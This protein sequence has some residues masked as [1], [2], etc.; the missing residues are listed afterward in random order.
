MTSV[1][2]SFGIRIFLYP[3]IAKIKNRGPILAGALVFIAIALLTQYLAYQRILIQKENQRKMIMQE[4][5]TIKDRF[6]ILLRNSMAAT[7][8]LAFIV[9]KYGVKNDFDSIAATILDANELIDAVQITDKG[10]ITHVYPA[11]NNEAAIGLDLF[12]DSIRRVEALKAVEK[13]QLTFAGPF[14]LFQGG[15]AVVG[16]LP[17]FDDGVFLGFAAVIVR[18]QSLLM[19]CGINPENARFIYQFSKKNPHTGEEDF[20][21]PVHERLQPET[22]YSIMIPDGEWILSVGPKDPRTITPGTLIFAFLGLL[23]AATAGV[24]AWYLVQQPEKLNR[25]VRL[26]I[27]EIEK[28]KEATHTT[29]ERISD[30]FI[31]L[32]NRWCYTYINKKAEEMLG[33][34]S[35]SMI[36]TNIWEE[37]PMEKGSPFYKASHKALEK[38]EYVQLEEY[39]EVNQLWFQ[40]HI[41][42]SRDGLSIY[43]RDITE[44]KKAAQRLE[45]SEKYFRTLIEKSTDGLLLLDSNRRITFVS[46]SVARI[47][48]YEQ[49]DLLARDITNFLAANDAVRVND[50]LNHL[51]G[52]PG[53][54]EEVAFQYIHSD[55]HVIWLEGTFTNYLENENIQAVVFNFHEITGRIKV[56]QSLRENAEEIQKLSGYLQNVREEERTAI[57]R[58][59]H[60]VLGQQLTALKMDTSWLR[61]NSMSEK[62]TERLNGMI[63]LID[64]TI[65]TV[66]K[67]SSDLRPGILDDFGLA[68][69]IE[70]QT[71]EFARKTGIETSVRV[72]E[73][74]PP[75]DEKLATNIFRIYQECLT[76]IARHAEATAV[77]TELDLYESDLQLIV[78]DNG[79]GI[80][81]DHVKQR[82]SLGL[83]GMRER[84]RNFS[85]DLSI[86]NNIPSG[87]VIQL[88][89]PLQKSIVTT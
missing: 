33:R 5:N 61:K 54:Y 57:A 44:S 84:A 65:R 27:S 29:L 40:L 82:K 8:T 64:E 59:I 62:F 50:A 77:S 35:A 41:Y 73:N 51:Y 13:K 87:T 17:M 60:D 55:A 63:S 22:V 23:L 58:E 10:V 47:T 7:K 86:R 26:K 37:Y 79:K 2:L 69:A 74:L 71:A 67:I 43:F 31:A 1:I 88:T 85:A 56:E 24:F 25:L 70:W 36:G 89:V 4:A 46:P 16:R 32:D 76:N 68:A 11:N 52:K 30:A 6:E 80:D 19:A 66:R 75:I 72:L 15:T 42:P 53:S 21:L 3:T 78:R 81:L 20:F 48:G 18:F 9:Q 28:Q 49:V 38:Q 45:A 14:E 34:D 83:I 39:Y 12:G